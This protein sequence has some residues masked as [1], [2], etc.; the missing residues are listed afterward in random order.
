[1][2]FSDVQEL[3][4]WAHAW[5]I[6]SQNGHLEERCREVYRES[7]EEQWTVEHLPAASSSHDERELLECM[8]PELDPQLVQEL[9]AE[10]N[11]PDQAIDTLLTL[12]AATPKSRAA[13][14]STSS[15][16]R[17]PPARDMGLGSHEQFPLLLDS[18]GWQVVSERKLMHDAAED[19]GTMWRDRAQRA[20]D[21]TDKTTAPA[22]AI[23]AVRTR[24]AKVTFMPTR[25]K[26]LW[27][28]QDVEEPI[29]LETEYEFRQRVGQRRARERA[30]GSH[31]TRLV[32]NRSLRSRKGREEPSACESQIRTTS[33]AMGE[34]EIDEEDEEEGEGQ[35]VNGED[36][37]EG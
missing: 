35:D 33:S 7:E 32:G 18:Q 28:E 26:Q 21:S 36:E 17:P 11:S 1:M 3:A 23:S 20:V 37:E 9:Y 25:P 5:P 12:A 31:A 27:P 34:A 24:G 16:A 30:Q 15:C 8:F 6:S 29:P 22:A 19:L 14:H 2:N 13:T 10:A 4:P